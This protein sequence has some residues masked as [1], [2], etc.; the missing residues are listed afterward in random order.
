MARFTS[1]L[2]KLRASNLREIAAQEKAGVKE[3]S[4]YR[5]IRRFLSDYDVGFAALGRLLIRLLPQ[6]PP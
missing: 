4:N 2:L 1:A 6:K 5:Q 3:N